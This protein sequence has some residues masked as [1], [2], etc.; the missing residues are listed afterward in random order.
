MFFTIKENKMVLL[1]SERFFEE[2]KMGL[3]ASLSDHKS[4]ELT[5]A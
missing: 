5:N 4:V 1:R 3:L 2:P